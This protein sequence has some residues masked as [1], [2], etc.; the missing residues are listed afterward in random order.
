M[1]IQEQIKQEIKEAQEALER[2]QKK[3]QE[4]ENNKKYG[5]WKPEQDEHYFFLDDELVMQDDFYDK[6]TYQQERIKVLNCFNSGLKTELEATRIIL[7]RKIRAIAI[8]LNK[9]VKINWSDQSQK[10]YR[11]FVYYDPNTKEFSIGINTV[12]KQ[13]FT[14]FICLNP[15]FDTVIKGEL[16]KELQEYFEL[17]N[18]VEQRS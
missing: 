9:G 8:R 5:W 14:G 11:L 4:L 12:S 3:L 15:L 10:K 7:D 18:L 16:T 13:D 1:D 17:K 6:S 2:A